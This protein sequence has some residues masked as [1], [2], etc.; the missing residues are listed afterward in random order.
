MRSYLYLWNDAPGRCLVASG[1]ELIDLVPTL[2]TGGLLLL[3][4][5]SDVAVR[6]F[7]CHLDFVAGDDVAALAAED[8]DD[9]GDLVWADFAAPEPPALPPPSVAELLYFRHMASPL[10]DVSIPGL[11]NRFLASGHDGGWS[12]RLHYRDWRDVEA[13]LS[14]LLTPL[15]W[16]AI[17]PGL[18]DGT[19]AFWI[20][21]E[22]VTAEERTHD[23]DAVLRR[24]RA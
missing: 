20:Q 23:I 9:W 13:A 16:A 2:R 19:G 12:L 4:H 6:D 10:H 15:T 21:G 5:Q 11:G 17:A 3:A 24:R 22:R 1:L 8:V 14:P 18:G 7:R